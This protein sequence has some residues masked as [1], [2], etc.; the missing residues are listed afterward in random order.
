MKEWFSAA[1]LAGLPGMPMTPRGVNMVG[2]RGG[3]Q[4]RKKTFG[5]GWEYS[6]LTLPGETQAA[7]LKKFGA[8]MLPAPADGDDV[9][10]ATPTRSSRRAEFKYD[11]EAL[12]AWAA[13]RPQRARDRGVERAG[14][15]MQA[16][17]LA[18]AGQAFGVAME[19]VARANG[20][21]VVNLRNWFYGVNGHP[22]ARLYARNDWAAML[23]PSY[24]GRTAR[25]ECSEEAWDVFKALYLRRRAPNC[26]TCYEQVAKIAAAKGWDWPSQATILRRVR[27]LPRAVRV[28]AREG[29]EALDLLMP[30]MTRDRSGFHAMEAVNGDGIEWKRYCVWP[31]GEVAR[32]HTWITQDLY[33]NKLLAWRTDRSENKGMFRLAYGDLVERFGIPIFYYIDNTMAAASKWM[34]GGTPNRYRWPIK[35][36]DPIGIMPQMGTEVRFVQPGHGQ[37]K[38]IE[39]ANRELRERVDVHPQ[40]EGRGT[41]GRPIPI[42]DFVTLME[43]EFA[44]YNAK[45]ARRVPN[46]AGRSFDET[47]NASYSSAPIRKA[48][49]E[50]RRLWLLAAERIYAQRDNGSIVLGRGPHGENRYWSEAL[51]PYA[52]QH[53]VVRFDPQDFSRPVHVYEVGGQY[54][55]EAPCTWQAGFADAE[56]AQTYHRER[57]RWKR[58]RRNALESEKRMTTAAAASLIETPQPEEPP[59]SKVVQ[60]MRPRLQRAANHDVDHDDEDGENEQH[61]MA[62]MAKLTGPVRDLEAEREERERHFGAAVAQMKVPGSSLL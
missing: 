8:A 46:A 60:L 6:F 48:T 25:A 36:E 27:E 5:K 51:A 1:E 23:V 50:Q 15:L 43:A 35:D 49:A 26:S 53:V 56:S 20:I 52:G 9:P 34:T 10:A 45:S 13:T 54:V 17:R 14:L 28:L 58:D 38:P 7:A 11:P 24:C 47:F 16:M 61:F 33:S 21:P 55:G 37:S 62:A 31:D 59:E 12:W 22:G 3:I 41:P 32:P 44:A 19:T 2:D 40:F 29:A 42:A 4:R 39:R 57:S 18:E 30:A